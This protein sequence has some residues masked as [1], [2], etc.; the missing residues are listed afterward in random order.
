MEICSLI[1]SC[2]HAGYDDNFIAEPGALMCLLR[3]VSRR[4]F[5]QAGD[6]LSVY[7]FLSLNHPP[8][9]AISHTSKLPLEPYHTAGSSPFPP[10][11][12]PAPRKKPPAHPPSACIYFYPSPF[13]ASP[14]SCNAADGISSPVLSSLC[15]HSGIIQLIILF[16]PPSRCP[17]SFYPGLSGIRHYQIFPPDPPALPDS[18]C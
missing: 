1:P 5:Y 11:G 14:P 8:T 10:A 16:P 7:Y 3:A 15:F 9:T 12:G 4:L 18:V 13:P 6:F 2:T 17:L